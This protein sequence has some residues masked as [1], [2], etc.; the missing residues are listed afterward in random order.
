MGGDSAG[1]NLAAV[2]A[3]LSKERGG[4]EL[5]WQLLIYP[6]ID[7]ELNTESYRACAEGFGL[8]LTEMDWFWDQY[9][10]ETGDRTHPHASPIRARSLGGLPAAFVITAEYDVLRDEGERYAERLSAE[11]VPT[12]LKRYE[13]MIHGFL[14]RF[15]I[16]DL[17]RTALHE[18]GREFQKALGD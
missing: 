7:G 16:F 15:E 14:R 17:G 5:F 18:I 4:P 3:L 6:V 12:R 8:N 9:V 2:A 13:G 1:G 11:G 10:G